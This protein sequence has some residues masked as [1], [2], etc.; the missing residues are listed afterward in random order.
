MSVLFITETRSL[1]VCLFVLIVVDVF[2]KEKVHGQ[3]PVGTRPV[4]VL[5]RTWPVAVL[6]Y[7]VL[8]ARNIVAHSV[9]LLSSY[10]MFKRGL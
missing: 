2:C 3:E 1:F 4:T 5:V 7:T 8:S 6:Q 10:S 9:L